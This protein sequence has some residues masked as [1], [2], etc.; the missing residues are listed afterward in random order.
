[1]KNLNQ[2]LI[3]NVFERAA[4]EKRLKLRIA[5]I[6]QKRHLDR[7]IDDRDPDV[8]KA[9][10]ERGFEEHLDKLV[11]DQDILVKSAV[12]NH[13]HERHLKKISARD[14][15][16]A[17]MI[18]RHPK[19]TKEVLD[20]LIDHVSPYVRLEVALRGNKEHLDK[21]VNDYDPIV[22]QNVALIGA[23]VHHQQLLNDTSPSVRMDVARNTHNI[24]HLHKLAGDD[25]LCVRRIALERLRL[26]KAFR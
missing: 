2:F 12:I 16:M 5:K 17:H 21:L 4:D 25:M 3:E 7:L 23:D 24:N 26:D 15:G 13:G 8:R 19:A 10:A 6:G 20:D 14:P 1:M 11:D 9:V 18:V 22:R